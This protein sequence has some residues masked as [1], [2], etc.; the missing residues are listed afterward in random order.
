MTDVRGALVTGGARGIGYAI[1]ETLAA[2]GDAVTIADVDG[3]RARESCTALQGHGLEARAAALDVTDVGQVARV[4]AEAD[5][6]TPLATV[7]CNA[8]I[9]LS[10]GIL[11]TSEGDFDRVLAVNVKGVF[12]TMQAA[13]RLMVP[14]GA[15]SVVAVSSTSGFTASSVPMAAYDASKAAV[16]ML[17]AA[18]AREVA[19]TGVRV[20]SVAPGTVA[21]EL[22]KEVLPEEAIARIIEERI[23]MGRLADPY[24]IAAAV[25]FLSSASATYVTGHTLVVDGGWLT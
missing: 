5:R 15:G 2:R 21:T 12:F 19:K 25:A 18:A 11:D 9:G 4:L 22:V 1:A 3:D 6:E 7:V 8:G 14:R 13:L 17:T 16:K 24:E 20:N 23:P 10:N